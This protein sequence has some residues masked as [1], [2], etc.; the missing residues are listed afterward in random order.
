M[1]LVVSVLLIEKAFAQLKGGV[2]VTVVVT[3]VGAAPVKSVVTALVS[4]D[5]A[6]SESVTVVTSTSAVTVAAA[7]LVLLPVPSVY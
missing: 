6:S 4:P 3:V 1:L 2:V 5:V 7:V